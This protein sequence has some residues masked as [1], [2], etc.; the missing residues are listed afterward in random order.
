[1]YTFK[2]SI[3]K[4]RVIIFL[5]ASAFD[6]CSVFGQKVYSASSQYSADVKVFVTD[7]EYRADLI[8]YKTDK[9]YRVNKSD[10]NG[11]WYFTDKSYNS[12]KKI[13]FVDHEYNADL[14]IFFTDKEYRAGWKNLKKK[15]LMY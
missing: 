3:I 1:M 15:H 13:F 10:N 12:D 7:K 9:A 4:S 6:V 2:S 8:V 14:T 11:I 5:I